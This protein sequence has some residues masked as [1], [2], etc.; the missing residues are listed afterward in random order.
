MNKI[1][2]IMFGST[3]YGTSTPDSDLDY[4]SIYLPTSEQIILHNYPKTI[5]LGRNKKEKERNTK[6]DIDTEIFSLDRY[7]E[8]L[9]EGQTVA[10]DMLFS[11]DFCAPDHFGITGGIYRNK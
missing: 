3:L 10:L 9:M 6:D 5:H 7:L 11:P 1:L 4:K 8:L 2:T